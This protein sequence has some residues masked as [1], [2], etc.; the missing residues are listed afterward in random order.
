MSFVFF[1]F[2]GFGLSPVYFSFDFG[3]FKKVSDGS[4]ILRGQ[5]SDVL[6]NSM[7]LDKQLEQVLKKYLKCLKIVVFDHPK[8]VFTTHFPHLM[9]L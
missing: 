7:M 6:Y 8:K 4:L 9:S 5:F 1:L 3:P 2:L